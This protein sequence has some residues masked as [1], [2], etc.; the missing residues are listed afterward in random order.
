MADKPVPQDHKK[1]ATKA[2]K[3]TEAFRL[4]PDFEYRDIEGWKIT[5]EGFD[6]FIPQESLEDYFVQENMAKMRAEG[7]NGMWRYPLILERMFGVEQKDAFLAHVTDPATGRPDNDSIGTLIQ[8]T[9]EA[10]NPNG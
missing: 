3:T 4:T 8:A 5:H 10:V 9:F 2:T 6:I 1:K 7:R